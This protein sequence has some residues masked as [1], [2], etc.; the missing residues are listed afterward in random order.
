MKE[1]YKQL[2]NNRYLL[3]DYNE[4]KSDQKTDLNSNVIYFALRIPYTFRNVVYK[5]T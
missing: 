1:R 4:S 3:H 5:I 2:N